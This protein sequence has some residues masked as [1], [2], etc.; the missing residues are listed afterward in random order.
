[1]IFKSVSLFIPLFFSCFIL[2]AQ[3][4]C[5]VR[6]GHITPQDFDISPYHV[7]TSASGVIIADVGNSTFETNSNGGFSL[8]FKHQRRLKIINK[9]GFDLASV[10]IPLYFKDGRGEQLESLE[11]ATYNLEDGKVV[12]IKLSND[13]IFDVKEQKNYIKKKF[14]MPALKEGS[15]VEY[16]Y[17]IKSDY[18]V[19]LQSWRF[20]GDYPRIWSEY[21][22]DIPEFFKYVIL[23]QGYEGF[24]KKTEVPHTESYI[25]HSSGD[26]TNTSTLNGN[27]IDHKWVMR[28]IPALKEEKFTTS[29]NNFIAKI[30]F[31]L[32]SVQFPD[33][34]PRD[35]MGTWEGASDDLLKADDFGNALD[36]NNGWL[37]DD[38]N[39][40]IAGA[41]TDIEKARNIY[42]Y[43]KNNVKCST[44][45]NGIWL[46]KSLKDVFKTKNGNVADVNLL[47]VTMLRHENLLAD[48]V[49]LSTTEN[50]Y[51]S[52]YYPKISK[53]NYVI[54]Q[55]QVQGKI[56]YL[57]ATKSYLGF[58]KLCADNYNGHAL[59]IN[60]EATPIYFMADSLKEKKISIA[61]ITFDSGKWI[62]SVQSD[63]G[64]Y[65]SSD[66]REK[67]SDKGKDEYIAKI[68]SMYTDNA[69]VTDI[70]FKD[71]DSC[72]M[73]LQLSYKIAI[74][75]DP[76]SNIIYFDPML[77]EG[78][79]ENYFK[80]AVRKYPVE[81][82]YSIDETYDMNLSIPQGYIVDELPQSTK[83]LFNNEDEG[84][85]E[86]TIAQTTSTTVS[87]RSHIKL[88][89][90]IFIPADYE[91]LRNFFDVIV[92]KH[93]EQ[94]VFKKKTS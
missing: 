48:A 94:I 49:I 53:F 55:L 45:D 19:N 68:K 9:N 85:F 33:Q 65:E 31:Q 44:D 67:I 64:Y 60:K 22:A 83:V 50:G 23:A 57:D 3:D 30:E 7:D 88:A 42:Y 16:S 52:P 72:E 28:N 69:S 39:S 86:Y 51:T 56:Y 25:V 76:S 91:T 47:L 11:A 79:D 82:P 37:T 41:T 5:P 21:E 70:K 20:Q 74:D 84:F 63:P 75:E 18:I 46:N 58:G 2:T 59:V 29:I 36:K 54:C 10:E 1:M 38:I 71:L 14:T 12:K 78:H 43:V 13:A 24:Y 15:I 4:K 17:T 66:I 81:M 27:A 61:T 34:F 35:Y 73:P 8:L 40:I 92:K 89:H 62:C 90:A 6:F 80:S 26:I 32:S 93:S 77:K 87:L